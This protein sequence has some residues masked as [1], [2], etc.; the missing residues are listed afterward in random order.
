MSES[1]I[2]SLAILKVN[3][4]HHQ[5]FIDNFIPFIQKCLLSAANEEVS[6]EQLQGCMKTSFGLKIPAGALKTI[7]KRCAKRGLV[8]REHGIYRRNLGNLSKANFTRIREKVLRQCQALIQEFKTFC[9]EEYSVEWSCSHSEDALLSYLQAH[10]VPI[11]K[12]AVMGEPI[13]EPKSQAIRADYLVAA[14]VHKCYKEKPELFGYLENLAKGNMLAN[15]L[16]CPDLGSIRQH[17]Q[18]VEVYFD[19]KVLLRALGTA[20]PSLEAPVIELMDLVY[21][22]GGSL[23]C[24]EHTAQEMRR[25]LSATAHI[26]KRPTRAKNAYGETV[27]YSVSEGLKSSDIERVKAGVRRLLRRLKV[28]I[29]PSPEHTRPLGLDEKRFQELLDEKVG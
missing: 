11:M 4:D 2:T 1:T 8:S 5:D 29:V 14:F 16:R 7:L 23:R 21:E 24:F 17:F 27:H 10:S 19:T 25:V 18:N 13:S 28:K 3:W 22:R 26:L 20:G 6:L 9:Q 12:A 15:V